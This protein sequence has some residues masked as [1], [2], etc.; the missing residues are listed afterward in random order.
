MAIEAVSQLSRGQGHTISSLSLKDVEILRALIVPETG[1]GVEVHLTLHE[2]SE[3]VL[4]GQ[5]W[6][7][8]HVYS[9]DDTGK[10][11]EHCKEF[12]ARNQGNDAYKKNANSND[13]VYLRRLNP[14]EL[15]RTLQAKGIYHG[16]VF[17]NLV[18][19][20]SNQGRSLCTLRVADTASSMPHGVEQPHILHP[21]TLDSIFQAVYCSLP[22]S[23]L[24]SNAAMVPRAFKHMDVRTVM[25]STPGHVFQSQCM[26]HRASSQGMESSVVVSD[27]ISE[28]PVLTVDGL[29]Y[30][31]LGAAPQ[32]D[33]E[34]ND[35][36]HNYTL[37]WAPD[38]SFPIP[39]TL[40]AALQFAANLDEIEIIHD[41][42]EACFYFIRRALATLTE[43]RILKLNWHQ[44]RL[45]AWL[46]VQIKLAQLNELG[47]AS[48][49]WFIR[50]LAHQQNLI[51]RVRVASVDGEMV[52]RIG[53][54][55]PLILSNEVAP[56]Q[57]M[58]KEDLLSEYYAQAV[59]WKRSYYQVQQLA[60]LFAHKS[61]RAKILEVGAGT[62]GCTEVVLD[63]LREQDALGPHYRCAS[64]DF[65]D[66]SSGFFEAASERFKKKQVM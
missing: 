32:A 2:G 35:I 8:F 51:N 22:T 36:Q 21:T 4:T 50:S 7:E 19:I 11:A 6:Q 53:E 13:E 47:P 17:K 34:K 39:S 59:R 66:I 38:I 58:L 18:S 9:C 27:T 12:I 31:S 52:C 44:Q 15:Y 49:E 46:K 64:Y 37:Q 63:A 29:Y 26:L 55:L 5:L 24:R 20:Q 57:L 40:K 10:W 16:D 65:T 62:G 14:Q 54:N 45:R 23:A 60:R 41:I 1:A 3:K 61:P 48:S 25:S 33:R 30:Q 56:L 42:R 43:D 28:D